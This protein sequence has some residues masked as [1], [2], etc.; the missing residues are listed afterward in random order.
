[1]EIWGVKSFFLKSLMPISNEMGIVI[2]ADIAV[3]LCFLSFDKL[4]A[5]FLLL[6]S[7]H[8][9]RVFLGMFSCSPCKKI[10]LNGNQPTPIRVSCP[11]VRA[12]LCSGHSNN[13]PFLPPLLSLSCWSMID[14]FLLMNTVFMT[15]HY[16][17]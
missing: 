1:M 10:Y 11:L 5:L 12:V 6:S 13:Q 15:L 9:W 4:D 16:K 2:F 14:L 7:H 8:I 17:L 3:V